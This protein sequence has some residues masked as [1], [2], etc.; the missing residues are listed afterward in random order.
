MSIKRNITF[1]LKGKSNNGVAQTE[2]LQIRMR[3]VFEGQ[4]IDFNSGHNIDADKWDKKRQQVK[5]GCTNKNHES[6][7]EINEHLHMMADKIEKIFADFEYQKKVPTVAQIKE[8][9]NKHEAKEPKKR[10]KRPTGTR[11]FWKLI[12]LFEKECGELNNWTDATYEKFAAMEHHLRDFKENLSLGYFDESG[13]NEYVYFLQ[14]QLKMRNSTIGKQLGYLKWFLRWCLRKGYP[15]KLDFQTFKPKL[16]TTQK[17]VIFLTPDELT[18]L[19]ECQIPS[20]KQYLER[21]R[22]VFLFCCF[23]GLRY[24]DAYN[25]KKSD[26]KG[27]HIEV[28]TIKT[29]DSLIIELNKTSR[30]I[31]EKYKDVDLGDNKALPVVT[32]QR[33]NDYVK[34]L[35][36]LAGIDEPIRET[37]YKGNERIDEVRPKYKMLGTHTGRRTFIVN[38][39]SL[40]IPANVV[41]K[42][43][44]HSDYKAMKPYIDIVDEIK[45]QSMSKF[46]AL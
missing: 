20:D 30:A 34:E 27:D 11:S 8:L 42:W 6:S 38:A 21:V 24:S 26:V 33:M 31:L 17:K 45:V 18:K 2:S 35:G 43:T 28:T 3:V 40:G 46:D 22:D 25:L 14:N 1:S 36:E 5:N 44:G 19:R 32:N 41:M 12:L 13:L 4:R 39:L 15:V 16:K 29:T 23:T 10:T 7:A 37:Y 9:F